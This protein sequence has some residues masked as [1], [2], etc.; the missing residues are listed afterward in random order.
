M[1]NTQSAPSPN[2]A[3]RTSTTRCLAHLARQVLEGFPGSFGHDVQARLIGNPVRR[4][5]S[6]VPPP[7][8]RFAGRTGPVRILVIGGSQGATRLNAVVPFALKRVAGSLALD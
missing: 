1:T 3:F 7:A 5:I 8:A 4:D 6:A 2:A